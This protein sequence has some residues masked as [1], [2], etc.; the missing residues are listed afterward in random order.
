[1]NLK[2]KIL[3][4]HC[5]PKL[6]HAEIIAEIANEGKERMVTEVIKKNEQSFLLYHK[7]YYPRAKKDQTDEHHKNKKRKIINNELD[8]IL[9]ILNFNTGAARECMVGAR[10]H[11][12]VRDQP[13]L[14]DAL[15]LLQTLQPAILSITETHWNQ[16]DQELL[17][18]FLIEEEFVINSRKG[19]TITRRG[20]KKQYYGGTCTIYKKK[21]ELNK[22]C[23]NNIKKRK[24][25]R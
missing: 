20:F 18:K 23:E 4:C 6:C 8:S 22:S 21:W 7:Y 15:L 25:N 3:G 12:G 16:A 1:M 9:Q 19:G 5:S 11:G 17:T 10:N 2:G 24:K 14:L 13:Q